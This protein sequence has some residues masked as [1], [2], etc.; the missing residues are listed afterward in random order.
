MMKKERKA[1][2][3]GVP[4]DVR[5]QVR[6]ELKENHKKMILQSVFGTVVIAV[7]YG[8][9]E[10]LGSEHTVPIGVVFLLL[11]VLMFMDDVF[12]I[13]EDRER[14]GVPTSEEFDEI[15]DEII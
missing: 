1:I 3:T 5:T 12:D 8:I 2:L 15:G 7:L 13:I 9:N 6:E 11:V 14:W 4:A 10:L